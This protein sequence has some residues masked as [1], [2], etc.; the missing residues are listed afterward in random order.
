VT[1][2]E[3]REKIELAQKGDENARNEIIVACQGTVR[4][5]VTKFA[6]SVGREDLIDD[7]CQQ[8]MFGNP[9][10]TNPGGVCR[11][12]AKYNV[13]A[14]ESFATYAAF[15]ILDE[16]REMIIPSVMTRNQLKGLQ[17]ARKG[18]AQAGRAVTE[19]MAALAATG[20]VFEDSVNSMA[21]DPG[22]DNE[23]RALN[24]DYD[25]LD[26]PEDIRAN[27]RELVDM[28]HGD[29]SRARFMAALDDL[30]LKERYIITAI[31]GLNGAPASYEQVAER[32]GLHRA[33]VGR[34]V[35]R[36][37][38]KLRKHPLCQPIAKL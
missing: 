2:Q 30:S 27:E 9:L 20:L 21:S 3:L 26:R 6:T 18:K 36:A 31:A 11:A 28:I 16:C 13:K 4:T 35:S 5:I 15:W 8:A 37:L 12:I 17:R 14:K 19:E 32:L 34:A 29:E 22:A 24:E 25:V 33:N 23:E 7:M 1:D 38:A 10:R